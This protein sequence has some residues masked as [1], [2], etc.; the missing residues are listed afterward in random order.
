MMKEGV[1]MNADKFNALGDRLKVERRKV[2]KI[3]DKASAAMVTV[4]L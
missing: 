1:R 2:A 3:T 4:P